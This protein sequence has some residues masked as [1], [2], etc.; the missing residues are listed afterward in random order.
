MSTTKTRRIK[1]RSLERKKKITKVLQALDGSHLL[2]EVQSVNLLIDKDTKSKIGRLTKEGLP[3]LILRGDKLIDKSAVSLHIAKRLGLCEDLDR[4]GSRVLEYDAKKVTME[5]FKLGI[6][7]M[8]KYGVLEKPSAIPKRIIII[9]EA[10]QLT[11]EV[12]LELVKAMER[13]GAAR[14]FFCT[15]YPERLDAG[16]RSL[17]EEFP[18]Q[19]ISAEEANKDIW[20]L[21]PEDADMEIVEELGATG[22]TPDDQLQPVVRDKRTG[23]IITGR[24]RK[25][26]NPDW[27]EVVIETKDDVDAL[28]KMIKGD[29]QRRVSEG[30]RSRKLLALA[31]A[32]K[33]KGVPEFDICKEINKRTGYSQQ[34]VGRHLPDNFKRSYRVKA[35]QKGGLAKPTLAKCKKCGS[36]HGVK[37]VPLCEKHRPV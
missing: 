35:G 32:L 15:D 23:K 19:L 36:T 33:L 13:Y 28:V 9:K 18:L 5:V 30:E 7:E 20:E 24:H 1:K 21:K 12:A 16:L 2:K 37:R 3:H 11:K 31:Y 29:T 22:A 4:Y 25:E 10:S 27:W 34:W 14:L 6:L 26:A 17:C 8:M